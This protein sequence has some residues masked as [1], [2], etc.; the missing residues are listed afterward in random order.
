M[1]RRH[2]FPRLAVAALS[3]FAFSVADP[4]LAAERPN[5]VIFLVDDQGWWDLGVQ[6]HELIHSPNLDAFAEEGMRFTQAYAACGVCSP[7]RA[8]IL[9]GRTPYRNGVWRWLPEGH[10]TH[11]RTSEIVL[12]KLLQ[13]AGYATCHSGK[14]HLNG[15]FNSPEQPQPDDHGFDHWFG[16]QNNAYPSH[17]NPENFVRNGEPVGPLEGFSAP[18]VVA[19][20]VEWLRTVPEEQ[21]FFLSLWTHEPHLPIESD[22]VFMEL[23]A[24]LEPEGRRQYYGNI[25]QLDHAFGMLMDALDELGRAG[26][27]FVFFTSDNGPEGGPLPDPAEALDDPRRTWGETGGLRGRK[28]DS[29]EGGVRVPGIARWPGRIP[30]GTVSDEPVIGTDLFATVLDM[31]G[32]PLP[33]DRTLD[34]VSLLPAF[35]GEPLERPVP[36]FWKTHIAP[37]DSHAAMRIGDWKLVADITHTRFQLYDIVRDPEETRDL[38]ADEPERL[39]EM[40]ERFHRLWAEIEAEGPREWWEDEPEEF[41]RRP[42]K[43]KG[44]GK[45]KG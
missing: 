22:P 32:L 1:K 43:G 6:G 12:P 10:P 42:G 23:Y 21:P 17:R 5:V 19:E 34:G 28:R 13:E 33:V 18:L 14:W 4:A 37:A 30:A 36:L 38:A 7:S 11:L 40:V 9:T 29:H 35:A 27:T 15:H 20:A 3:A 41:Q 39:A 16:T 26:E 31:A 2:A 45:G 8:A 44:K 25:T 24:D